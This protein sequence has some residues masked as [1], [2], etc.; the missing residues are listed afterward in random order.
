MNLGTNAWH[1]M[2]N[3][4]GKLTISLERFAVDLV[5]A[6]A[7]PLLRPG[8]Y[9][10]V[11]VS[12][13]G[14]GMNQATK[15]RIFEPFFTTK[16]PDEGTGLG[17]SVVLGIMESH[18][19]VVTVDSHPSEGTV[20]H[21]YFPE[22]AG[23]AAKIATDGDPIENGNGER[24]LFVDDEE[25]IAKLGQKT[26]TALDYKVEIATD[27]VRALETLRADP[28]R[29]AVVL[30]DQT[31]PGMTGV[32][33]AT[34]IRQI[35]PELP[36]ILITGHSMALGPDQMHAAGILRI[37]YKPTSMRSMSVAVHEALAPR[38]SPKVVPVGADP[39]T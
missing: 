27:P 38:R 34:H 17:L 22:H 39:E 15:E 19:G 14:I 5:Q 23:V 10:R 25:L 9:A 33:L 2:R 18:D 26:L 12:D 37:L 32:S 36:V 8:L 4:S 29:F 13:T 21:L 35:R 28:K 3:K 16:P 6:A 20:F 30:T 1:A 7:R 31:M 24:I 11:S